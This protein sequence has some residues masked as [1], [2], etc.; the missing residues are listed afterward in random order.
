[1]CARQSILLVDDAPHAASSVSHVLKKTPAEVVLI[2]YASTN[3][4]VISEHDFALAV[5]DVRTSDAKRYAFASMLRESEKL[6]ELPIIFILEEGTDATFPFTEYERAPVDYLTRPFPPAMLL[7]KVHLLLKL[8]TQKT[9]FAELKSRLE[10]S[11]DTIQQMIQQ[12]TAEL[13]TTIRDL[14]SELERR[15]SAEHATLKAKKE[16]QNIFDAIGHMTMIIDKNYTIVAANRATVERTGLSVESLLGHKCHEIFHQSGRPIQACPVATITPEDNLHAKMAEVEIGGKTYIISCTPVYDEGGNLDKIIHIATDISK[17]KQMARELIQA[18][19][20]EAIGSLASGIAHD[21]NNILSAV[22]GYTELSLGSV[23]KGSELEQDLQQVYTAG[24]RARDLV[25]QILNFAR[26]TDEEPKPVRIDIIAKEAVKFLR[27]TLPSSI[28]I[29]QRIKGS[30]FVMANPVKIHQLI[31]NLCTNAAH[32]MNDSGVLGISLKEIILKEENLPTDK[33]MSSGSYLQFEVSD[34]GGGIHPDNLEKIFLPYFTT[35]NIH[36]GTGMGL[37]MAR[38]IAE[39]CGGHISVESELGNGSVFTVF[40]P[41]INEEK[42]HEKLQTSD[43]LPSGTESILV[44]DD[45]P[46]ICELLSRML[47]AKGYTVTTESDS[48]K[49]YARFAT[50]P[51]GYDLI[52]TDL[53]MPKMPGD[54]LTRKLRAVRKDI[55]IIIATGYSNRISEVQASELGISHLIIKPYAKA[56]LLS[57]V[58]NALDAGTEEKKPTRPTAFLH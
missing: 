30:S 37:A 49:A 32:V 19:R 12:R 15:K 46:A 3:Q 50:H 45:E 39:E 53:T 1:M 2:S 58:R 36:E 14:Q 38:S 44:V 29:K 42:P 35:K 48:E 18:H 33:K 56:A 52:V 34:T 41:S 47:K 54:V 26:K 28:E 57:T 13:K 6:K 4:S 10:Q 25:K 8:E 17:Q 11:E 24:I 7:N 21:F 5:F 9:Q 51:E 43:N 40:L 16:W 23:E 27:S 31:M 55:P 20:M 22:L